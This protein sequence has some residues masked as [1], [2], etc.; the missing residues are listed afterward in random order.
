MRWN[1]ISLVQFGLKF[2]WSTKNLNFLIFLGC[3]GCTQNQTIHWDIVFQIFKCAEFGN[4]NNV[5]FQIKLRIIEFL[6]LFVPNLLISCS[7]KQNKPSV[8][9]CVWCNGFPLY[10]QC[11]GYKWLYKSY[12]VCV[13]PNIS[14]PRNFPVSQHFGDSTIPFSQN[15]SSSLR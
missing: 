5:V 6:L 12:V 3:T 9:R 10:E 1:V 7:Y 13:R 14:K 8:N 4:G 2:F 11:S 15:F